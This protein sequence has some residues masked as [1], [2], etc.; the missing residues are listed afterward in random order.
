MDLGF[1]MWNCFD[2]II[3][4]FENKLTIINIYTYFWN[5]IFDFVRHLNK[6]IV[7]IKKRNYE[8][9]FYNYNLFI[10]NFLSKRL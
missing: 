7:I 1:F 5:A 4:G 10:F 2:Y 6:L 9:F 8:A 3:F